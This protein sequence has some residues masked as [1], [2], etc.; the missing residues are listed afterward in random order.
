MKCVSRC[1]Q[2]FP[3][4]CPISKNKNSGKTIVQFISG[5]S[6]RL[7]SKLQNVNEMYTVNNEMFDHMSVDVA[8]KHTY[9]NSLLCTGVVRCAL[10]KLLVTRHR[11]IFLWLHSKRASRLYK[12][13]PIYLGAQ[14]TYT[15]KLEAHMR[16]QPI[17]SNSVCAW[18][19]ISDKTENLIR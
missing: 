7:T 16:T 15:H 1:R 11:I 8:I 9:R 19:W 14:Y 6:N 13:S 3:I 4:R 10:C 5:N 17:F 12:S 18:V 2:D